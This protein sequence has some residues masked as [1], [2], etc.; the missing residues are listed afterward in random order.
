M[1]KLLFII[2]SV[3]LLLAAGTL[4]FCKHHAGR[5][6]LACM[7]IDLGGIKRSHFAAPPQCGRRLS[8]PS[9]GLRFSWQDAM[10]LA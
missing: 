2:P 3:L 6:G 8:S 9:S 4:V 1:K 5:T 7:D 10:N